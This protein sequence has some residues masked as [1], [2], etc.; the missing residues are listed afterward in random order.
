MIA[1]DHLNLSPR[2]CLSVCL[3]VWTCDIHLGTLVLWL[4]G[5]DP[6][7]SNGHFLQ[8]SNVGGHIPAE[9]LHRVFTHLLHK[10]LRVIE[11]TTSHEKIVFCSWKVI[12]SNGVIFSLYL[13]CLVEINKKL[14]FLGTQNVRLRRCWG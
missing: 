5:G 6:W 11:P 9:S 12:L 1:T 4:E 2:P 10:V 7:L 3:S 14:C 13:I 8:M